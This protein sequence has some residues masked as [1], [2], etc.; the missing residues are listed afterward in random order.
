LTRFASKRLDENKKKFYPTEDDLSPTTKFIDN[1]L[2]ATLP[3]NKDYLR[4]VNA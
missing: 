3:E 2:I 4:K 1:Q